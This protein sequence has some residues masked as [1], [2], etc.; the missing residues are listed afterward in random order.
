MRRHARLEQFLRPELR[1]LRR[2]VVPAAP[3][4]GPRVDREPPSISRTCSPASASVHD[5]GGAP[6]CRRHRAAGRRRSGS[7]TASAR[8]RP[9]VA[10]NVGSSGALRAAEEVRVLRSKRIWLCRFTRCA[11]LQ[12]SSAGFSAY[13][14]PGTPRWAASP[15]PPRPPSRSCRASPGRRRRASERAAVR[16]AV[17]LPVRPARA[18]L[19]RPPRQ[20]LRGAHGLPPWKYAS[21][22]NQTRDGAPPPSSLMRSGCARRCARTRGASRRPTRRCSSSPSRSAR[23]PRRWAHATASRTAGGDEQRRHSLSPWWGKAAS[24]RGARRRAEDNSSPLGELGTAAAAAGAVGL[25]VEKGRCSASSAPHSSRRCR[26]RC[27]SR[28]HPRA[29]RPRRL[30]ARRRA[31]PRRL[32]PRARER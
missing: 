17:L 2:D 23:C 27:S 1:R 32:L 24:R 20:V 9:R 12:H 26:R 22:K 28:Q 4:A 11:G 13:V 6:R 3:R 10:S 29:R 19:G 31:P 18:R 30:R 16:P 7:T 25:C 15:P 21:T 8:R 5:G 14:R